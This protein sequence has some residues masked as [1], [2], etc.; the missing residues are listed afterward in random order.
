[1]LL[2]ERDGGFRGCPQLGA[3]P[4]IG[5]DMLRLIHADHD[6]VRRLDR[7]AI[8]HQR[9]VL[10]FARLER[11]AAGGDV[12]GLRRYFGNYFIRRL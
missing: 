11:A 2:L 3:P 8:Q 10:R 12:S 5:A 9:R 7:G 6:D 1:M 4:L